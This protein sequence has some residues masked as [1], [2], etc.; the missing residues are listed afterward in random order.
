MISPSLSLP[1]SLSF[2]RICL[3]IF[4]L[5][6]SFPLYPA[7]TNFCIY[8]KHLLISLPVSLILYVWSHPTGTLKK[9]AVKAINCNKV[10]LS[11]YVLFVFHNCLFH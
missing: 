6:Q 2:F 1:L 5:P 8:Y 11:N 7:M 9:A 3:L 10:P 4:F